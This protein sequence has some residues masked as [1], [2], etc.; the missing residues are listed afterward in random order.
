MAYTIPV[1]A[2]II[3]EAAAAALIGESPDFFEDDSNDRWNGVERL[4]KIVGHEIDIF[5]SEDESVWY[6][7]VEIHEDW[8]ID[9]DNTLMN[10]AAAIKAKFKHP[11]LLDNVKVA[12]VSQFC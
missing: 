2:F 6:M 7:G 5:S 9:I 8:R 10:K 4:S 3:D 11:L 1:A 12:V